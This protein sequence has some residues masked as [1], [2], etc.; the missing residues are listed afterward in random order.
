MT[1]TSTPCPS[2]SSHKDYFSSTLTSSTAPSG[3][4]AAWFLSVQCLEPSPRSAFSPYDDVPNPQKP[5]IVTSTPAGDGHDGG[6]TVC[7]DY[8]CYY[9][10]FRKSQQQNT[11]YPPRSTEEARCDWP[12]IERTYS[13]DE[14]ANDDPQDQ[15]DMN[16]S[17]PS[18]SSSD[19][20][21]TW[22]QCNPWKPPAAT[23]PRPQVFCFEDSGDNTWEPL[24][25]DCEKGEGDNMEDDDLMLW[26][27]EEVTAESRQTI[28]EGVLLTETFKHR[29]PTKSPSLLGFQTIPHMES[30]FSSLSIDTS[31][32]TLS[33]SH[34]GSDDDDSVASG[35]ELLQQHCPGI[36]RQSRVFNYTQVVPIKASSSPCANLGQDFILEGTSSEESPIP[37]VIYI[38]IRG[39]QDRSITIV[40]V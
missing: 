32:T 40:A 13:F 31:E 6:D 21:E 22:K 18:S 7:H 33:T 34:Y 1:K 11:T 19:D 37:S 3:P 38:P 9:D 12:T 5:E 29:T 17:L 28:P 23:L 26:N 16:Q 15:F 25:E 10:Y 27:Q 20:E 24:T 2:A 4:S 8:F 14:W 39:H 35:Q 30:R 36:P